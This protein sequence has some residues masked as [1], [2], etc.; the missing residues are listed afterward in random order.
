MSQDTRAEQA[1]GNEADIFLHNIIHDE[2]YAQKAL[3]ILKPEYFRDRPARAIFEVMKWFNGKYDGFPSAEAIAVDLAKKRPHT[4][5]GLNDD[6]FEQANQS[7]LLMQKA[8]PVEHDPRW[9]LD[10]TEKF[11]RFEATHNAIFQ[12]ADMMEAK[13]D[14]D[15]ASIVRLFDQVAAVG[16]NDEKNKYIVNGGEFDYTAPDYLLYGIVQ[17]GFIYSI[18]AHPGRGKTAVCMRIAAHV[19]AGINIGS[20]EVAK[21]RVLYLAGENPTDVQMRW[22]A[23]THEMGVDPGCVEFV[24]GTP[25]LSEVAPVIAREA[26]SVS[27]PW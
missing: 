8:D 13:K 9:L 7:L 6:E 4:S 27:S 25:K 24:F 11:C 26:A 22:L 14:L 3:S 15:P 2:V 18:T 20:V 21:G 5:V 1:F 19:G 16:F 17:R 12:A 23:L 10:E